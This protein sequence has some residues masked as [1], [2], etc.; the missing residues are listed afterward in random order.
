MLTCRG[1]QTRGQCRLARAVR[2][3]RVTILA[4]LA[5]ALL[6]VAPGA[7]AQGDSFKIVVNAGS[8]VSSLSAT[9]ISRLFLKKTVRWSDGGTVLPVDLPATSSVRSAFS[10]GVHDK[11]VAAIKVYW[12]RK[13]FTGQGVPPVEKASDREVLDYVAA[14]RAAIGYVSANARVGDGVKVVNLTEN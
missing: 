5:L 3:F 11:P 13:I 6:L 7:S 2:S 14:N 10:Q 9:E 4:P 8:G 1:M 12:Q